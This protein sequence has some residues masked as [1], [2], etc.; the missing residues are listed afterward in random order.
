LEASITNTTMKTS[1]ICEYMAMAA[2]DVL[3]SDCEAVLISN[4]KYGPL[5][6]GLMDK[7]STRL[8]YCK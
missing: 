5:F 6:D 8:R 3:C 2:K 4:D 1:N 7:I